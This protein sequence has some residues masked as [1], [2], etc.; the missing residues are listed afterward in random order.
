MRHYYFV[1]V[2]TPGTPPRM[3]YHSAKIIPL[4]DGR[5]RAVT[6]DGAHSGEGD[7]VEEACDAV[8]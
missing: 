6:E 3:E 4:D 7:S 2:V 8:A 1:K 5:Y